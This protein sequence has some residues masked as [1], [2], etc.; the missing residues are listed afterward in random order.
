VESAKGLADKVSE[1]ATDA[2]NKVGD[3][4]G[5]AAGAPPAATGAGTGGRGRHTRNSGKK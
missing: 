3:A 4:V 1:T 5:S 2:V